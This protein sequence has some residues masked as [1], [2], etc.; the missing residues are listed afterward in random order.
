MSLL[1][2]E[3]DSSSSS[4]DGKPNKQGEK[5]KIEESSSSPPKPST[6]RPREKKLKC[7]YPDC[8]ATF[9]RPDRLQTH[10]DGNHVHIVRTSVN[11]TLNFFQ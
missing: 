2:L 11:S 7:H 8:S 1:C 10:I 5:R 9:S 3:E 6:K 4:C